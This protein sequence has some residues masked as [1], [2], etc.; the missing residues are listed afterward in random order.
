MRKG[1]L[2]MVYQEKIA[3]P[4]NPSPNEEQMKLIAESLGPVVI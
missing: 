3:P 4:A 1:N 2:M